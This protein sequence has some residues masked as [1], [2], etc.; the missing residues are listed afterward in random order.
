MVLLLLQAKYHKFVILVSLVVNGSREVLHY[1]YIAR[2]C[3]LMNVFLS[4]NLPHIVYSII[5]MGLSPL[6]VGQ[7]T[8]YYNG[9]VLLPFVLFL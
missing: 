8:C 9:K 2:Y 4:S 6:C 7:R 3:L 1:A 5:C